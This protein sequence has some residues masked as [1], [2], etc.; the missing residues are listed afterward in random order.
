V[1]QHIKVVFIARVAHSLFV[2]RGSQF[3]VPPPGFAARLEGD[4]VRS[5]TSL[6]L[7]PLVTLSCGEHL[8]ECSST[9]S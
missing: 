1:S 9:L 7:C 4:T 2:A 6:V 8:P 5:V 3:V